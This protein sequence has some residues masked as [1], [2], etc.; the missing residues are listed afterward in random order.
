MDAHAGYFR[1][2]VNDQ[3]LTPGDHPRFG[4]TRFED[5]LNRNA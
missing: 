4:P 5:S 2:P 1:T 3:S